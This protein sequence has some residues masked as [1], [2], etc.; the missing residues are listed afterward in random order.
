[1]KSDH[2]PVRSSYLPKSGQHDSFSSPMTGTVCQL[3]ED[4]KCVGRRPPSRG[5][6]GAATG[7]PLL[8]SKLQPMLRTGPPR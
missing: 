2:E 6:A 8:S 1:M 5:A 7:W 3:R 4:G